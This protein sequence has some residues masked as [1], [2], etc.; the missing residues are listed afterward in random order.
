V[1]S[2]PAVFVNYRTG[3]EEASATLIERALSRQF[4]SK[5]IFRVSKA[6]Q[7]GGGF[8]REIITAVRRSRALLAV[9]GPRWLTAQDGNGGRA[10]DRRADMDFR[11]LATTLARLVP[12]LKGRD[13]EGLTW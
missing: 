8:E 1:I 2:V 9:I 6:I 4:G 5:E 11:L 13:T 3:D 7:P 10:L 12:G